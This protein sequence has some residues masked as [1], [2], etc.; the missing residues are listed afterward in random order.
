MGINGMLYQDLGRLVLTRPL[1]SATGCIP[2]GSLPDYLPTYTREQN[3]SL[4]IMAHWMGDR[5]MLSRPTTLLH[6]F[7]PSVVLFLYL[8]QLTFQPVQGNKMNY[9]V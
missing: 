8:F 6:L 1:A 2:A 4:H 9:S 7:L 3:K 5:V